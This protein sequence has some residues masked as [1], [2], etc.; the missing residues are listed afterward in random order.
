MAEDLKSFFIKKSNNNYS[1]QMRYLG[2]QSRNCSIWTG[3]LFCSIPRCCSISPWALSWVSSALQQGKMLPCSAPRLQ[4]LG[5]NAP[6]QVQICQMAL[7]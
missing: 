6:V 7:Q 5:G 3:W 4:A 2:K 1:V